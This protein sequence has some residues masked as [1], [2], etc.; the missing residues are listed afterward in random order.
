MLIL[1]VQVVTRIHPEHNYDKNDNLIK[2]TKLKESL[3]FEKLWWNVN[4]WFY[5]SISCR[6]TDTGFGDND[7]GDLN[8]KYCRGKHGR[9]K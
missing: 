6:E 5:L 9:P 7:V 3:T 2:I 8:K 4:L 1:I